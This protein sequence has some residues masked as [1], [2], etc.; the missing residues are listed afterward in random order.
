MNSAGPETDVV[1]AGAGLVGA[2]LA[3]LLGRSG[4][5]VVLV[6]ERPGKPA[7]DDR[8]D[9]PSPARVSTFTPAVRRLLEN[10]HIWQELETD[11]V[12]AVT[13]MHIEDADGGGRL[14]FDAAEAG[15]SALG[16]VMENRVVAEALHRTIG[17]L[18]TVELRT[19]VPVR[20]VRVD[21]DQVRVELGDGGELSTRLL[22]AADGAASPLRERLGIRSRGWSYQQTAIVASIEVAADH[23]GIAWQRFL[24]DGPLALLP[25]ADGNMSIVWSAGTEHARRLLEKNEQEF[26]TALNEALGENGRRLFGTAR[27]VGPR[28]GFALA[29]QQ[30]R[31]YTR[32]RVALVGDAAH[33]IHP[34]AGQGANLGLVDAAALAQVVGEA[35]ASGRDIGSTGVL[36]RYARW[37]KADGLPMIGAVDLLQRSFRVQ[38]PG[39][40]AL[41]ALGMRTVD[42]VAP[43]KNVLAR[44]A[45]GLSGEMPVAM[46]PP[47]I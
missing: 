31:E 43:L 28:A 16:Y 24:A 17:A 12:A 39:F 1:I 13:A 19:G 33:R 14:R 10:L 32:P 40:D 38:L 36:R 21:T 37:R 35:I 22:V 7:T 18:E 8:P 20:G 23:R 27:C 4:L 42:A 46:R 26:D 6:E 3:A 9:P 34:L 41:R 44:R 30:A 11:A 45:M 5:R 29:Y 15:A 47:G 25:L 2:C